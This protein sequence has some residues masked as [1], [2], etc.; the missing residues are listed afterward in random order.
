MIEMRL[1]NRTTNLLLAVGCMLA[2][3]RPA[4]AYID[5]GS[6]SYLLQ[7]LFA[8]ILG[9]AFVAKNALNNLK[10]AVV[11]RLGNGKGKN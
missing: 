7:I 1:N 2:I 6:G 8:G 5:A 4:S 3:C 9:G 10:L 11:R